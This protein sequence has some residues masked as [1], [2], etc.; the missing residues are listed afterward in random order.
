MEKKPGRNDPCH[1]G[2]GKKY[3]QCCLAKDETKAATYTS[4]GKR[5][6]KASVISVSDKSQ[7]VFKG[8]N[9]GPVMPSVGSTM[10]ALKFKMAQSDYR[11]KEEKE[12]L[13]FNIPTAEEA[14][15]EKPEETEPKALPE[16][17]KPTGEDFHKKKK[18]E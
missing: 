8:A 2:S 7:S 13:P 10:E 18:K 9:T 3:K 15:F 5:K 1:C 14:E 17:F 4:S 16:K 12:D 6:F 11:K